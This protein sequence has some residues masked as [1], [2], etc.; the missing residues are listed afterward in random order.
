MKST[1]GGDDAANPGEEPL[2]GPLRRRPWVTG[3]T[4]V[5]CRYPVLGVYRLKDVVPLSSTYW[6]L[7]YIMN[8]DIL[9][10]TLGKTVAS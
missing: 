4:V 6:L 2:A 9:T 3:K 8:H 1:G 5:Y 7:W 10:R